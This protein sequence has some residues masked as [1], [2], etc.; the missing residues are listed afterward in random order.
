V[1]LAEDEV[2]SPA[3]PAPDVLV[4]FNGP[5]LAKFGPN[6]VDGGIVL[7]DSATIQDV[8]DLPGRRI[9]PVPMARIAN[10]LGRQT[11]KNVVALGALAAVTHLF[12]EATFFTALR[13]AF[14]GKPALLPLNE[15]AFAVGVRAA[16]NGGMQ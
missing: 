16:G 11:V 9:V 13:E 15:Q 1:R 7:Y 12:P 5:S 4:A 14:R 2:L 3:A 8:A 10:E 6:V